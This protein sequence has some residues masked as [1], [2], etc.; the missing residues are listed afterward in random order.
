M[1]CGANYPVKCRNDK[2]EFVP[3]GKLVLG[4]GG[5]CDRGLKGE[6]VDPLPYLFEPPF[7]SVSIKPEKEREAVRI[8]ALGSTHAA[9]SDPAGLSPT[10]RDDAAAMEMLILSLP[11]GSRGLALPSGA[12]LE[13]T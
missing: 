10:V 5:S 3:W 1:V 11:V 6:K 13:G 9:S 4:P 2:L 7:V 8:R 12:V